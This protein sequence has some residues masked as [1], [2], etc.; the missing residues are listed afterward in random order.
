MP[1][2]LKLT[3]ITEKNVKTTFMSGKDAKQM[4]EK[5]NALL[6]KIDDNVGLLDQWK[7]AV[8]SFSN[9]SKQYFFI[10]DKLD[11]FYKKGE[12]KPKSSSDRFFSYINIAK[13][14]NVQF[15]IQSLGETSGLNTASKFDKPALTQ[16]N[17]D[18]VYKDL[19]S[20]KYNFK[21]FMQEVEKYEKTINMAIANIKSAIEK[22]DNDVKK[23]AEFLPKLRVVV[24]GFVD[25]SERAAAV[26]RLDR[27]I[28]SLEAKR[29]ALKAKINPVS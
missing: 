11:E 27:Q 17:V 29:N 26:D 12:Y 18:A 8:E 22:S 24:D 23:L 25:N 7:A 19:T 13:Y 16:E 3:T 10:K 28:K 1:V 15:A 6:K 2:S 14:K 5:A 4:A 20:K 9:I 21:K